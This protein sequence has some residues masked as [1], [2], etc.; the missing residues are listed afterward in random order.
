MGKRVLYEIYFLEYKIFSSNIDNLVWLLNELS[1]KDNR[2]IPNKREFKNGTFKNDKYTIHNWK[3]MLF[4]VNGSKLGKVHINDFLGFK[5][6]NERRKMEY[7]NKK[8]FVLDTILFRTDD[9]NSENVK[10]NEIKR[11]KNEDDGEKRFLKTFNKNF[12]WTTEKSTKAKEKYR[13]MKN[14]MLP[15]QDLN[16]DLKNNEDINELE[17][18]N[19]SNDSN[20]DNNAVNNEP[21]ADN[22]DVNNEPN[23]DNDDVN[24]E[25]NAVD[26]DS[27]LIKYSVEQANSFNSRCI[28]RC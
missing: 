18:I 24:N 21:N 22:D 28:N 12:Q 6:D 9:V 14:E 20:D 8:Y 10:Y 1:Q 17:N 27:N 25:P 4:F 13:K 15:Q 2:L 19:K 3:N 7:K 16:H 5:N 11:I 23:A 26:D